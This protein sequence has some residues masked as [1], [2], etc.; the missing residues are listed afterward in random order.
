MEWSGGGVGRHCWVDAVQWVVS[1]GWMHAWHL[2][3]RFVR[4]SWETP[5]TQE[6]SREGSCS[7]EGR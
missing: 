7:S 1:F 6:E 4:A 5:R 2:F 3:Q